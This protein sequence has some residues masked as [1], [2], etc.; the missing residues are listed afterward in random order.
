[1]ADPE[2]LEHSAA[3]TRLALPLMARHGIPTTPRNYA[4]WYR[5]VAGTDKEL[6]ESVE[7]ILQTGE[8]VSEETHD[9][10][11]RRFC[12]DKDETAILE[13]RESLRNILVSLLS[14]FTDLGEQ[15]DG[16][17]GLVSASLEKL[18]DKASPVEIRTIVDDIIRETKALSQ[19]G[20]A[21]QSRMKNAT[22]ELEELK[23][24]FERAKTEALVDFLTGISN[25][26]AFDQKLADCLHHTRSR[27][28]PLCLLM[29][30]IDHF[31]QFNDKYGHVV[32]DEVLKFTASRIRQTVRG[33]DFVAR[34]GGEEF[35]VILPETG[36]AGAKR[37]A[38]NL[39]E[40]FSQGRLKK[41][42]SST[43]L[44]KLTVSIGVGQY[45][46]DETIE[47]LIQRADQALYFA[48]RSG[49]DR[50]ATEADLA[51]AAGQEIRQA[52][53]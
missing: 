50:V 53:S 2:V 25:R 39:R 18:S 9:A 12:A 42:G 51:P 36:L 40:A 6:S 49:R 19:S 28:G 1:M 15:S 31:K 16:Y 43:Y 38:E 33:T 8:P 37:V 46:P 26:K 4:V 7:K 35:A 3:L 52:A 47:H 10:L 11:Y 13:L 22:Q 34:Y 41:A 5:F 44:G 14:G 21:M 30:D 27:G 48:K 23:Q 17:E 20:K 29:I 24:Q 45:R 32:G